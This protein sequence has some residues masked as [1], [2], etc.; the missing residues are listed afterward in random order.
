MPSWREWNDAIGDAVFSTAHAGRVVYLAIDREEVEEIGVKLG[1]NRARAYDTFQKEMRDAISLGWSDVG[2]VGQYPRC[3]THLAVQVVAAFQMHDDESSSA[4]AYWRR[5]RQFLG[6]PPMDWPPEKLDGKHHK[7]LWKG[8]ERWANVANGGSRG[9]IRLVNQVGG[10]HLVAEPLGQC[11]LRR[12]DLTKLRVLFAECD[13]RARGLHRGRDLRDLVNDAQ[14]RLPNKYFTQHGLRV[15]RNQDRFAAALEQIEAEYQRFLAEGRP[16]PSP[17][18]PQEARPTGPK[19]PYEIAPRRPRTTVLLQISRQGLSGGLYRRQDGRLS[20]VE[21]D[22]GEVLWRCYLRIGREGSS[23]PH[24]PPH[25]KFIIATRSDGSGTFFEER[26]KC[27]VGDDVLLLI[28]EQNERDWPVIPGLFDGKLIRYQSERATALT[29]RARLAGLPAGWLALRFKIQ[30]DLTGVT[31]TDHWVV[32]VD[33]DAANLRALGGLLLRR[34]VWMLGAGP[35]V[36]VV[37]PGNFAQIMVDGEPLPLDA[38]RCATLDLGAGGY[39]VRLPGR[40]SG[41]VR[42]QVEEPSRTEPDDSVGWHRVG[43]GWPA[44]T[45]E[46]RRIPVAPGGA[47]LN[48]PNLVGDWPFHLANEPPPPIPNLTIPDVLMALNL[49]A[50][51]RSGRRPGPG[52]LQLSSAARTSKNPLVRAML[53][54]SRSVTPF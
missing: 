23:P 29:G 26:L 20:R 50:R 4:N 49:A 3:L 48:G 54:A 19:T 37:G 45:A 41:A 24:K 13:P 7:A 8:L 46:R 15:L 17:Q 32:A 42:I 28:P 51:L 1:L 52:D 53:R 14:S 27:R 10:N 34:G 47:T 30:D 2:V 22:L 16:V 9:R 31:L 43:E 44:S 39:N 6:E 33:R 36:R 18:A 12:A 38:D 40:V 21:G 25:D 5:L 11:L 35:T